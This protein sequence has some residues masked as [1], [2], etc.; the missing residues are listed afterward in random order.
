MT[1]CA[2]VDRYSATALVFWDGAVKTIY[3]RGSNKKG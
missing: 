2:V 1:L 3:Q